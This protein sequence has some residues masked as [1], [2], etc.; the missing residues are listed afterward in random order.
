MHNINDRA[1]KNQSKREGVLLS[2]LSF[3]KGG[4]YQAQAV[5][6]TSLLSL[7]PDLQAFSVSPAS[8]NLYLS[9]FFCLLLHLVSFSVYIPIYVLS[10]LQTLITLYTHYIDHPVNTS[11]SGAQ[12]ATSTRITCGTWPWA[13]KS[14]ALSQSY[15][16]SWFRAQSTTTYTLCTVKISSFYFEGCSVLTVSRLTTPFTKLEE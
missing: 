2:F 7:L 9:L 13:N 5:Q 8:P 15:Q 14:R 3:R 6:L 11:V 4:V 10:G 12:G 1:D 16:E